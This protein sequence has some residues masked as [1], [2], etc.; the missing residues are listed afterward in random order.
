MNIREQIGKLTTEEQI[1]LIQDVWD[2][3]EPENKVILSEEKKQFLDWQL[4][5]IEEGSARFVTVTEIKL[6]FNQ[7]KRIKDNNGK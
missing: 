2:N 3:L 5:A 7:L 6:K 1:L 4:A